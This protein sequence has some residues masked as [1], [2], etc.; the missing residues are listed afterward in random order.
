MSEPPR[1]A[2]SADLLRRVREEYREMP[3]LRLTP[4][5]ATRL[6][7][8]TPS[9]CAALLEALVNEHFLSRTADGLFVRSSDWVATLPE[10]VLTVIHTVVRRNL[11]KDPAALVTDVMLALAGTGRLVEIVKAFGTPQEFVGA[12]SDEVKRLK[13]L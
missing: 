13:G 7:G 11:S 10:E 2:P 12:V 3:S 5:Q 4:S 1:V 9:E 8:L 6:F